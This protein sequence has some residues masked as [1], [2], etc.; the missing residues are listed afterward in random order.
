MI[1]QKIFGEHRAALL[2]AVPSLLTIVA[3]LHHPTLQ[4]GVGASPNELAR[5]LQDLAA[6]NAVFHVGMMLLIGA[7][8][9]GLVCLAEA[10]GLRGLWVRAG[11]VF[12]SLGTAL[13]FSATSMDGFSMAF[14]AQRLDSGQLSDAANLPANL[15]SLSAEIQGFTRG[16]L[17]NQAFAQ[18][19]L[20]IATLLHFRS[21]RGAASLGC[22]AAFAQL[23]LLMHDLSRI[24]PQQLGL[25]TL[26]PAVWYVGAAACLWL[27]KF[28]AAP[29]TRV[30]E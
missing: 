13:L 3:V 10:I 20:S 22:L 2:L 8:A 25:L 17:I 9:V 27:K 29:H 11:L 18:L 19:F 30:F 23:A 7:Q 5:G 4:H 24:G 14:L 15:V 26:V 16:G 1:A 12:Y 21:L 28:D 6:G